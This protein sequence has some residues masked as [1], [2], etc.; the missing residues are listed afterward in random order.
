MI[1]EPQEIF[2][3]KNLA[4]RLPEVDLAVI[5]CR[6]IESIEHHP[7]QLREAVYEIARIKLRKEVRRRKPPMSSLEVRRWALAL[8]SAIESIEAIYLRNDE[9]QALRSLQQVIEGSEFYRSEATIKQREPLLVIDQP[10]AHSVETNHPARHASLNLERLS[11]WPGAAP[12]LRVA[13]VAIFALALVAIFGQFGHLGRPLPSSSRPESAPMALPASARIQDAF[14]HL[15]PASAGA[16]V[17]F[18]DAGAPAAVSGDALSYDGHP[19]ARTVAPVQQPVKP[20]GPS[21]NTQTY[22]VPSESGGE[23]S[24]NIFRC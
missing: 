5:L 23:A 21:C 6:T 16:P 1:S 22:R 4:A 15:R 12:L 19:D 24:I 8:E 3:G 13:M 2:S 20:R 18:A 9:L 11:R 7:A 17:R 10:A 14:S